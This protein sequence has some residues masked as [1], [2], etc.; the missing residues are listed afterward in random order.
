MHKHHAMSNYSVRLFVPSDEEYAA[1]VAIYNTLWPDERQWPAAMWRKN[2]DVWPATALNQRFVVEHH[3]HITGMGA[4]YEKYWRHQPGTFHIE[5]HTDPAQEDQAVDELLYDTILDFLHKLSPQPQIVA[6]E[7]RDDRHQRLRFLHERGFQ[8]EMR[9]SKS[10]LEVA[11]FNMTG[12]QGLIDKLESQNIG[13]HTL[14]EM[15]ERDPEWKRNLYELR[16]AIVQDIPSVEPATK[17]SMAEFQ[18][19]ILDDPALA[20]DAWFIAVDE[21]VRTGPGP[22]SFVGMSN[23]WLNDPAHKRL[24]TGLTG[25]RKAYRRRGIAT[26]LKIRSIKFAQQLGAQRIETG[27]EENNPMYDL[28]LK[29]GFRPK[30]A[31]ISYRKEFRV[32]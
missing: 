7:A 3:G 17:P 9:T 29:L 22:G 15:M 26:A 31:W 2:D 4:C 1:I 21:S 12:Y 10:S 5:F 23:F 27:N 28:N 6:T 24:D 18:T 19:T 20:E 13:I 14:S 25:V 16:W 32:T 8:E 11:D 30:A